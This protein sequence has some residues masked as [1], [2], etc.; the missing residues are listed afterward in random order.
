MYIEAESRHGCA[1]IES[2]RVW[3]YA[4]SREVQEHHF[5]SVYDPQLA[6]IVRQTHVYLIWH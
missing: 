5:K 4:E 3:R 2:R 6:T 1:G